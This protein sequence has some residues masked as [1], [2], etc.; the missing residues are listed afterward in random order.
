MNV[1]KAMI[2]IHRNPACDTCER[3][4]AITRSLDWF[5]LVEQSTLPPAG[6]PVP[7]GENVVQDVQTGEWHRGIAAVRQVCFHIPLYVPFG[8]LLLIPPVARWFERAS[9]KRAAACQLP[10]QRT[11]S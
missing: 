9:R 1:E 11:N 8:L 6:T 3:T 10:L 7:M 2:R 4:S 5:G